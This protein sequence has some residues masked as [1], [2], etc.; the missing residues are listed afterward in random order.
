MKSQLAEA[1]KT[2][3]PFV[4]SRIAGDRACGYV[5]GRKGSTQRCVPS[6]DI[7]LLNLD[8]APP[9]TPWTGT[10]VQG[11]NRIRIQTSNTG[12]RSMDG[13][14]YWHGFGDNVHSGEFSAEAK[15]S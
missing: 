13:E 14:A 1:I 4:I 6:K 3:E 12:K 10:W 5:E 2:A 8:P 9:L 11:E 15:P 7:R